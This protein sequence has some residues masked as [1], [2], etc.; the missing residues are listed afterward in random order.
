MLVFMYRSN[1][2]SI[3]EDP[4]Q[5]QIRY[6]ETIALLRIVYLK[7]FIQHKHTL[8]PFYHQLHQND[9]HFY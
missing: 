4:P 8:A 1:K 3:A 7:R 6:K 2:K 9:I 5:P